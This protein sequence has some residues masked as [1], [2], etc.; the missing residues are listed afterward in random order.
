M[1]IEINGLLM[2]HFSFNLI[3]LADTYQRLLVYIEYA[4]RISNLHLKVYLSIAQFLNFNS[5]IFRNQSI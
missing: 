3:L 4:V 1:Y 5:S 2:N